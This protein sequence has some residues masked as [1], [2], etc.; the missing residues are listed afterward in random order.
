M[1]VTNP[2]V[3]GKVIA[4]VHLTKMDVP[5]MC[6]R[7][8]E[9]EVVTLNVEDLQNFSFSKRNCGGCTFLANI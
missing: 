5:R 1:I 6:P 7:P 2:V 4:E 3:A 8:T 9:L